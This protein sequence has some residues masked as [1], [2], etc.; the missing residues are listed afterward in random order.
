VRIEM[1]L[2]YQILI[3]Q[4][5]E[6]ASA[7]AVGSPET[8][9]GRSP[10]AGPAPRGRDNRTTA[11]AKTADTATVLIGTGAGTQPP[12][13]SNDAGLLAPAGALEG[14][15]GAASPYPPACA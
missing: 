6:V 2:E 14:H 10:G 12:A 8:P 15:H 5:T 11:S 3:C 1:L 9:D 13:S 7:G 4:I